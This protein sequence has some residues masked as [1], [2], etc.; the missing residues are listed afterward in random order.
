MGQ[1]CRLQDV[2]AVDLRDTLT[3]SGSYR[4]TDAEELV[5]KEISLTVRRGEVV[6]FVGLS[7]AGKSTLMD[8][9]PR[10]HDVTGGRI[11]MD[12]YDLR[13]LTLAS[14][15][16]QTGVVTQETFLFSE[17]VAYNIGYGRERASLDEIVQAARQ[18]GTCRQVLAEFAKDMPIL[19]VA[20]T[21]SGDVRDETSLAELLPRRFEL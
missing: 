8:L 20:E 12:G 6:A 17:S 4:Y 13:D 1:P 3:L 15:R 19:L 16:A 9:L 14:L 10:F 18:A 21:E 11:L 5:L 2:E 7:G